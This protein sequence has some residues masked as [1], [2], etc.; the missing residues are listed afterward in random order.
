MGTCSTD[1][2]ERSSTSPSSA[3]RKARFLALLALRASLALLAGACGTASPPPAARPVS[4]R[5]RFGARTPLSTG[6][7]AGQSWRPARFVDVIARDAQG[8][9]TARAATDADGR[10]TIVVPAAGSVA[11]RTH[12]AHAGIETWV[13]TDAEGR[14]PHAY[15]VTPPAG[16]RT[17]E[18]DLSDAEPI[19]GALHLLDTLAHGL[20]TFQSWRGVALPP[21]FAHWGRGVTTDW[22]YFLGQVP[23]GSGRYG[24]VVMGGDPGQ[25]LTTDTDE[26]D[27]GIVLHEL[28]HFA[29]QQR[30]GDS[31]IG[32]RHPPGTLTDPG[33][34]WEEG[35]ATFFAVAALASSGLSTAARYRDTIGVEPTGSCRVDQDVE[36]PAADNP[37]GPGVQESVTAILWDLADGDDPRVPLGARL[38]D[39]DDDGV[40]LGAAAVLEA[41]EAQWAEAGSYPALVSFLDFLVRSGRVERSALEAMLARTGE[42]STLLSSESRWPIDVA[43][44]DRVPGRIDGV[45]DPAPSGGEARPLNG[46]DAVRAYR[47]IVERAGLLEV[48]VAIEGSG[49]SADRTSIVLEL[50][51]RRARELTAARSESPVVRASLEVEAGV[52][53]IYVRSTEDGSRASYSLSA[54][55]TPR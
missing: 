17:M 55:H 42:P 54:S 50:R 15:V 34:A 35:R 44:G 10:S 12:V 16:A 41:M 3:S 7:S 9:E 1:P 46:L 8:R 6:L 38:P 30:T 48:E 24:V 51:D 11:I 27:E 28:G 36:T 22:S 39:R 2:R 33:V 52:Y 5:V 43:P 13:T 19:A 18:I 4:L 49:T 37:R 45:S 29:L 47:V 53:A 14:F 32:G 40:S 21:I 23:E 26:H 25:Q 31:S 20:E